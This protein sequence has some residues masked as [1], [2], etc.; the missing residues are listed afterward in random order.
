MHGL[1]FT[2][3][4]P[5]TWYGGNISGLFVGFFIY[6]K[7]F[8]TVLLLLAGKPV[9]A[10]QWWHHS[11]VLLYCWHSYSVRIATGAWF[12][13]MNYSVHSVMYGYFALMGTRYR[14][15]VTPYA[16]YITLLQL[17]Q[18][19]V[20]M[21]VTV[22]AVLYQAAG[23]ECHVNKTNSV[24]GLGMYLSYFV[25]FF[26]LFVDNYYLKPKTLKKRA[27]LREVARSVSR[28]M[29][30]HVTDDPE[31]EEGGVKQSRAQDCL[32]GRAVL[33][34]SRKSVPMPCVSA[35]FLV[36]F[37]GSLTRAAWKVALRGP[38][39]KACGGANRRERR[40]WLLWKGGGAGCWE[41][42]RSEFG[43]GSR[44]AHVQ[45]APR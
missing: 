23:D 2:C 35:R 4:A 3:C 11:T 27:S 43:I 14:K 33:G 10:L 6:S 45:R 19:L 25:L 20:G 30:Q 26:K 9:I 7:L 41:R 44:R 8:D 12:A 1:Y 29:T 13:C 34:H 32:C 31:P 37:T 36:V 28:K 17:V 16:I 15:L 22:K 21:F 18:M 38:L 24:L 5:A 39:L 42:A 40:S